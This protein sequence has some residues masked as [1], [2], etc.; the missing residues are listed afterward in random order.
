M[1]LPSPYRCLFPAI[2]FSLLLP[3]TISALCPCN[4]TSNYALLMDFYT[5][6]TGWI[7]SFGKLFSKKRM[8]IGD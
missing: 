2:V 1:L 3:P 6:T 5:T 4:T 7:S 8:E